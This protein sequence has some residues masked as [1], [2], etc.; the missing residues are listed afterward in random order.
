MEIIVNQKVHT[1]MLGKKTGKYF[2]SAGGK[3]FHPR[4]RCS[5]GNGEKWAELKNITR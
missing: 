5:T 4:Q 2:Y 1:L 3:I